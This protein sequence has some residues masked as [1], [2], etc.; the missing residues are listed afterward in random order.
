MDASRAMVQFIFW[1]VF[2]VAVL[3]VIAAWYL[4]V[5]LAALGIAIA[6][7]WVRKRNAQKALLAVSPVEDGKLSVE[8]SKAAASAGQ[9]QLPEGKELRVVESLQYRA[10]HKRLGVKYQVEKAETLV[11]EGV[12]LAGTVWLEDSDEGTEKE[13]L[14]VVSGD[15]VLGQ[16]ADVDLADW[17]DEILEVGGAAKCN[18]SVTFASDMSISSIRVRGFNDAL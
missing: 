8:Q 1:T 10:N 2:I 11:V 6:A 9:L 16:L 15:M 5:G 3:S 17:Y 4:L 14:F 13:V 12:I 7:Y 18:L